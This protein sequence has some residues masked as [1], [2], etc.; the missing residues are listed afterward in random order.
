MQTKRYLFKDLLESARTGLNPRKNFKL[1]EGNNFYITIKDIHDDEIVITDKTCR[2]NDEAL[3]IINKRSKLKVGD[4]L[5]SSIGRIGDTAI[6]KE[7]PKNWNINESVFVFTIKREIIMPEFLC[8][9]L[10]APR[11]RDEIIRQST[12]ST[13][14]S[15]KMNKLNNIE[16]DVPDL[17]SQKQI[18]YSLGKI[19][20]AIKNREKQ[21]SL[22]DNLVLS[23]FVEMFGDINLFEEKNEWKS[24]KDLCVVYTGTTPKS[25]EE[26]N[27]NG[28]ILW[29]TPAELDSDTFYIYDT[30][31][32]ITEIGR[33]SKSLD[34]MPVNT[35]LLSTRAPIGKV[36]IVGKEMCCNQGFKNLKCNS[37]L[38]H[39]YL[40]FLLKQNCEYLNSLGSGTTFLELSKSKILDI[41]IPLPQIKEQEKFA[42]FVLS[43]E[44]AKMLL[45]DEIKNLQEFFE[46]KIFN[47]FDI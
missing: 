6:I 11:Y 38:N 5:F 33:K 3:K 20:E 34:L 42:K 14:A 32:K 40:Y 46:Y 1:G 22:F 4:I 23:R 27:W 12:G 9:M 37:E 25:G 47:A 28:D 13:F 18:C 17:D 30:A 10:K 45:K 26:K 39:I 19:K 41:K 24:I 7:E 15:I 2:V 16:F 8:W 35:V 29:V 36:A 44:E 31:R 43:I 21:I